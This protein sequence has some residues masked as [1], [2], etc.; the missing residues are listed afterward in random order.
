M[1]PVKFYGLHMCEGVAEYREP[2][3]ESYRIFIN[4]GTIKNMDASFSGLPVYVNHVD[5]VDFKKDNHKE[6]DGIVVRSFFNKADGKHWA[7]FMIYTQ[8]GFDAIQKGWKLSNAYVPKSTANGGLW[9]GVE[10]SKEITSAEYEHLALVPNPRYD[11]SVILTPEEFKAYNSK[12]EAELLRI[13]NSKEVPKKGES[14]MFKFFK[15]EKIENSAD[16]ENMMVELPKSKKEMTL[17]TLINEMD[18]VINMAGY[19]AEDHM[20]KVGNEE[21]SVKDLVAN[22]GSRCNEIEEMKKNM[23][24][25]SEDEKKENTEE[26]EKK[27]EVK[28]N[29]LLK[30]KNAQKNAVETRTARVD[31]SVDMVARGKAKYGSGN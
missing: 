5:E 30:V 7:E 29:N 8:A 10:Y 3:K 13:A 18:K 22:Y 19:A 16:F 15:R 27:E 31:L 2:D 25:K 26:E 24:E 14:K 9:H 21:M 20:V 23:A 6:A 1:K 28:K 11:E 17:S 12:K 4:E